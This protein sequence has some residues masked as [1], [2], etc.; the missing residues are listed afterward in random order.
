MI[1][2]PLTRG[3]VAVVDDEDAARLADFAWHAQANGRGLV[4]AATDVGGRRL[5][6]PNVILGLPRRTLVDHVDG[7]TLNNRRANLRAA[8]ISENA[9]NARLRSD[10][11]SGRKG[12][13]FEGSGGRRARPWR[14]NI[15]VGGRFIRLGYFETADL[16]AEAYDA[17]AARYF[18]EFA[19]TNAM[20]RGE[21]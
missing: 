9:A 3:Y 12:V 11:S 14:A 5:P 7:D 13:T 18:G 16:A 10:T 2:I 4:Y 17:A 1:R 20:I 15:S 19:R 21:S 6:M 8:T